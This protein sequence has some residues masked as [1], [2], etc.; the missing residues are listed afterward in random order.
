MGYVEKSGHDFVTK[1]MSCSL[2]N[3]DF[4]NITQPN[5][6]ISMFQ[7]TCNTQ[8]L[9]SLYR[10]VEDKLDAVKIQSEL[11]M[12]RMKDAPSQKHVP[13]QFA[14]WIC[15]QE[16]CIADNIF[17]TS[18]LLADRCGVSFW[19]STFV[20]KHGLQSCNPGNIRKHWP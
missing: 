7:K 5:I 8:C 14:G 19:K 13:L 15:M 9:T 3:P 1:D 4:E 6:T 11:F 2:F 17:A 10:R 12:V 18:Q 16:G 20:G